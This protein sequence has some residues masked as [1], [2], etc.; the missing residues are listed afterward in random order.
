MHLFRRSP[1]TKA[2][3]AWL[4][5]G[6]SLSDRLQGHDKAQ[7]LTAAEARLVAGSTGLA[8]QSGQTMFRPR[9]I[10]TVQSR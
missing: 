1:L 3:K 5:D 9:T 6:G 4:S 7:V 2:L 10:C 8:L